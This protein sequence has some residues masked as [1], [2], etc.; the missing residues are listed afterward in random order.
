[1][2]GTGACRERWARPSGGMRPGAQER[3]QMRKGRARTGTRRRRN[4]LGRDSARDHAPPGRRPKYDTRHAR[5]GRVP[6]TAGG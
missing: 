6:A 3:G 4:G 2:S 1:M 5:G